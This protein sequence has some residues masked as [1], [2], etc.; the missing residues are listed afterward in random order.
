MTKKLIFL[1]LAAISS[2]SQA[3]SLR[4]SC[5]NRTKIIQIENSET[6]IKSIF[7][8]P[9]NQSV[10]LNSPA[11]KLNI[12]CVKANSSDPETAWKGVRKKTETSAWELLYTPAFLVFLKNANAPLEFHDD[13]EFPLRTEIS[14]KKAGS[15]ANIYITDKLNS[16]AKQIIVRCAKDGFSVYS[17]EGGTLTAIYENTEEPTVRDLQSVITPPPLPK[18][19]A[20]GKIQDRHIPPPPCDNHY[21]LDAKS[22][23]IEALQIPAPPA[24]VPRPPTV[25]P[26]E[27]G[28]TR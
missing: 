25:N 1:S 4:D 12:D 27:S 22:G 15:G 24:D 2:A 23:K 20:S 3:E 17:K 8:D 11:G 10:T 5:L 28:G 21:T 9:S 18:V 14:V 19:S 7:Y 26:S 13:K 6:N 16:A